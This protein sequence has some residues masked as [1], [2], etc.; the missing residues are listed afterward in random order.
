[1]L[2]LVHNFIFQGIVK[3]LPGRVKA[4]LI[5]FRMLIQ[6]IFILLEGVFFKKM[7]LMSSAVQVSMLSLFNPYQIRLT[8]ERLAPAP[9]KNVLLPHHATLFS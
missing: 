1:M 6:D 5:F 7:F 3:F 8:K 2:P 9:G 4:G